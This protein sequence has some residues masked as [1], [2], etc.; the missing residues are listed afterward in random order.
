MNICYWIRTGKSNREKPWETDCGE[1]SHHAQNNYK[2][3]PFCG[4]EIYLRHSVL[5]ITDVG[6]VERNMAYS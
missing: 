2:F 6:Y 3:C 5:Q 1:K 4:K